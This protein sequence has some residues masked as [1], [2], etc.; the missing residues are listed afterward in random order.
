MRFTLRT[1]L[2]VILII[3]FVVAAARWLTSDSA[4]FLRATGYHIPPSAKIISSGDTHGGFHGDGE[5]YIVLETDRETLDDWIRGTPPWGV[6][7]W[8]TGPV[9]T[10]IGFHCAF[11]SSG[12]T[13]VSTNG[14]PARYFGDAQLEQVL[15]SD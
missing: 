11:G 3:C 6:A 14:G 15:G 12:V 8:Q 4:F 2:F 5:S 1:L 9:P 7:S 13:A 10:E